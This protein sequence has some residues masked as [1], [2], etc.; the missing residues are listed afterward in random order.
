[1]YQ[2]QRS[3]R[4]S[5]RHQRPYH[6]HMHI[7]QYTLPPP[8]LLPSIAPLPPIHMSPPPNNFHH[9]Y[10]YLPAQPSFLPQPHITLPRPLLD[11]SLMQQQAVILLDNTEALTNIIQ[12]GIFMPMNYKAAMQI[13]QQQEIT[14]LEF[15]TQLLNI[16]QWNAHLQQHYHSWN[17][18]QPHNCLPW[19]VP[20]HNRVVEPLHPLPPRQ[21]QAPAIFPPTPT[22]SPPLE[23]FYHQQAQ[24]EE[25]DAPETFMESLTLN[26][27]LTISMPE[28]IERKFLIYIP[29]RLER[30]SLNIR[31]DPYSLE[32][33]Y[34]VLMIPTL[35][36]SML[37]Q[38]Q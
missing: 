7:A 3:H 25:A 35:R 30:T 28:N 11:I 12:Q 16:H 38:A 33:R 26:E 1:M 15:Q 31:L 37:P 22:P 18:H 21:E 29:P 20:Y 19:F 4:R 5:H 14:T 10:N 9:H 24:E 36:D 2:H 8:L 27:S 34:V 13:L 32:D 17:T 6:H 23:E